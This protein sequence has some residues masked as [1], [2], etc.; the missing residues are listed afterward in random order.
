M[1]ADRRPLRDRT[2]YIMC[3]KV[4]HNREKLSSYEIR[5]QKDNPNLARTYDIPR[6]KYSLSSRRN[7][8]HG[9]RMT[10]SI[11]PVDNFIESCISF[12]LK[13]S[14]ITFQISS[15]LSFS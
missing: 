4:S 13:S 6:R 5:R 7:G 14:Q 9:L 8:Y 1:T 12:L 10:I 3:A 15:L 2:V 11:P